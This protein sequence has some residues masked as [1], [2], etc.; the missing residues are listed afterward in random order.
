MIESTVR[1]DSRISR[2]SKVFLLCNDMAAKVRRKKQEGKS[3][4]GFG[5]VL[6]TIE[7]WDQGGNLRRVIRRGLFAVA[8]IHFP[9]RCGARW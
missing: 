9:V 1:K 7:S 5:K 3:I 8:G 6:T 4:Y 2:D